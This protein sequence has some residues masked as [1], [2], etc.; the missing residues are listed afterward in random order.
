[1]L[2]NDDNLLF[3]ETKI[4]EIK[5]AIFIAENDSGLQLPHKIIST[6]KTDGEGNVWFFTTCTRRSTDIH[7]THF[8]AYLDYYQKEQDCS[9]RLSGKASIV[10][11]ETELTTSPSGTKEILMSD[12]V[13]MKFKILYA[14]YIENKRSEPISMKRK[15]ISFFTNIF[16]PPS[17]GKY[18]FS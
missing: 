14:E 5:F 7:T 10:D 12:V 16:I 1:M 6:I 13:L 17:D 3:L 11:E 2:T 4:Q 18:D 15:V 8:F 9:L